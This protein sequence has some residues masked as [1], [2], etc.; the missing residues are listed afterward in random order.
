MGEDELQG[1]FDPCFKIGA[2]PPGLKEAQKLFG[3]RVSDRSAVGLTCQVR[4]DFA[5]TW[6][7]IG[8]AGWAAN[9]NLAAARRVA[10]S[11]GG[12]IRASHG[13]R[14]HLGREREAVD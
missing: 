4:K 11:A 13:D 14:T 8:G 6:H 2:V 12:V 3:V 9:Q 7:F 1:T 5:R 10:R